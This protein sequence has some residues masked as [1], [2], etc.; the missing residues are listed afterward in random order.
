MTRAVVVEIADDTLAEAAAHMREQQTSS[1]LVME[2]DH[3]AGILTERDLMKAIAQGR[4]PKLT[5]VKDV[6]VTEVITVSPDASLLDAAS[7][8]LSKWIRHLPVVRGK[9]VVGIISQ[10]DLVG[11]FAQVL[12]EPDRSEVLNEG[13]LARARRLERIEHGDLD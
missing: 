9:K 1:L 6:M 11:A 4:D 7:L 13:Q 3:L 5:Q 8:M 12:H 10:R 2:G